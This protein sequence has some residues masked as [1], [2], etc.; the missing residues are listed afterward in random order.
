MQSQDSFSPK[1]SRLAERDVQLRY[2]TSTSAVG[3]PINLRTSGPFYLSI[4]YNRGSS[5]EIWYK[6][7]PK[8]EHKINSM[9]KNIISE[10]TLE[11]PE[12]WFSNH[13]ARKTLVNKMKKANLER[14]ST[15]KVT[16]PEISSL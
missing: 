7:Q 10:T 6:V 14:S 3:L 1:C 15:A 2:F 16:G 8:G 9:M 11:S 5:D 12:K 4:K 13:S